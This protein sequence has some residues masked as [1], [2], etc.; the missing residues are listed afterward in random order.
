MVSLFHRATI[1]KLITR[2]QSNE[3]TKNVMSTSLPKLAYA[4]EFMKNVGLCTKTVVYNPSNRKRYSVHFL[5]RDHK[6]IIMTIRRSGMTRLN[7]CSII[8]S[9]STVVGDFSMIYEIPHVFLLITYRF[10]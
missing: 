7:M 3:K 9:F 6:Y 10:L 1:K 4:R 8:L 2:V 5:S